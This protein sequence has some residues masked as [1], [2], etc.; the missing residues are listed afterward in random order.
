[1]TQDSLIIVGFGSQ[2]KA[3][4]L[5]LRDSKRDFVVALNPESKSYDKV[6]KLGM[7]TIS[8][9]DPNIKSFNTFL[10]LIPDDQHILFFEKNL[11]FLKKGAH[12]IYAHGYSMAR[13]RFIDTYSQ[14][15]HSLLAPKAIASDVRFQYE[16]KGKIGAVVYSEIEKNNIFLY[17][18]AKDLG[19]TSLYENHYEEETLADLFSEQSLLCSIIPY[20]SLKSFNLLIENGISPELA[21]MECFLE[22]KSISQAFVTMGPEEFFK[23]ISPN[24]L[25]GSE[26]GKDLLIN[27]HFDEALNKL[28]TD[29][30]NKNFYKDIDEDHT[31][32]REKVLKRW[33]H[34]LLTETHRKLKHELI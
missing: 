10:M 30:K 21:F 11:S 4:A 6:H 25:I 1:M 33:K 5:N 7:K 8:L 9:N 19:F 17:E 28:F 27:Q 16:T 31:H 15:D 3:W 12:F 29:I 20:A 13:Y 22:L 2:A 24:A 14:F 18:L 23:L 34:E 32:L 26:K